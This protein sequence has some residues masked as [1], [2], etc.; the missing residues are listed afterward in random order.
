MLH[1]EQFDGTID[2]WDA[3]LETFPDREIF[4]TS[5]WI[6]FLAESQNAKPVILVLRNDAETVG[7]FVGLLVQ[8]AGCRILGSPFVGWT[9]EHMGIRLAPGVSKQ[10]A[11]QALVDYAFKQ[12]QCI[13]L[14][15]TDLNISPADVAALGFEH[16][17]SHTTVI[18]LTADEDAIYSEM[19]SKSC[20]YCIRKAEKLGVV[21]EEAHD[22]AFADEYYAQLLDVFSKQDLV[23]TYGVERVKSL[24]RH[25]LPSGNLLLLRARE[26]GGRCIATSIFMGMHDYSYFWGNASWRADQHFCPNEPLQWYA[27][28]YWKRR[29]VRFHDLG[30]GGLYKRKYGGNAVDHYRLWKSKYAW[31]ALA[32]SCALQAFK[33]KQRVLGWW[34][35]GGHAD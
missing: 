32:R 17:V 8:K 14:E 34:G 7:Y 23:P 4:Q 13:H 2:E 28:R 12:L 11:V 19:S 3:V 10:E 16:A 24:I 27:I 31:I 15:L 20:R 22:E 26:P 9:T 1:F 29:G 25:L 33:F 6:R 35:G 30:G 5:A 18:D 21:I